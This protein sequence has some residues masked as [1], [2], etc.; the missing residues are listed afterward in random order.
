[1]A[2]IETAMVLAAGLGTRNAPAYGSHSEAVVTL[3]GR[4][5]LDQC[6]RQ[7]GGCRHKA[8]RG[9]VHAISPISGSAAQG[10]QGSPRSPSPTSARAR[11][12]KRRRRAQG[13]SGSGASPFMVHNSDSVWTEGA[14]SNLAC[15][16]GRLDAAPHG[17]PPVCWRTRQALASMAGATIT[18]MRR[19]LARRTGSEEAPYAVCRRLDPE[20]RAFR[21]RHGRAFSLV[22]DF[23]AGQWRGM[24]FTA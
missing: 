8:A 19:R 21:G 24:R 12:W 7:A 13:A 11:S 2:Q 20:A 14:R 4:T 15:V 5:L 9:D 22:K 17:L 3:G 16:D 18:W 23:R 1:M 6:A 10:A